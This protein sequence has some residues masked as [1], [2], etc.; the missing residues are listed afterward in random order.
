[1]HDNDIVK[2]YRIG[3]CLG[4][5]E[6]TVAIYTLIEYCSQKDRVDLLVLKDPARPAAARP[7]PWARGGR[8]AG[9]TNRHGE[10]VGQEVHP[11]PATR[12]RR[13]CQGQQRQGLTSS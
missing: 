2:D 6:T 3:G 10:S 8:S 7:V 11:Y 1:M 5:D 12:R 13:T 9:Q 4:V